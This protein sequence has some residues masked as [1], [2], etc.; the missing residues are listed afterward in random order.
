M[1]KNGV[2]LS[3]LTAG[4]SG[5]SIFAN[6]LF[7]SRADPLIFSLIRNSL[8]ALMLTAVL[9]LFGQ[10]KRLSRVTKKEWGI[11]VA[12][13]AIG[14]GIPFAMF[15]AGLS[16][17]G[18]VNGN[19][20]QK[21]LFLWVALFAV[22]ILKEKIGKVQLLGYLFLFLGMF[23]FGGTYKLV[24][25][26]GAFLVLGATILWA[27]ENVVAKITLKTV[28]PHIVAWG[29]MLF[30]LPFLLAA[31]VVMGK[32]HL[33]MTPTAFAPMPLVVSSVLLVAYVATWYSTLSLAPAT[34]VS[35]IL[36]FAPVVTALLTAIV[37]HE[38]IVK[39]QATNLILL[40]LG[41]ILVVVTRL[42]PKRQNRSV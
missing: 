26:T 22:P 40:S 19:I 10:W 4:I 5:V 28:S 24:P 33:L 27:I 41:T 6:A 15:F 29:R 30:G 9:L 39:T 37:L 3:L 23:V 12:I 18:A 21:T 36:V 1:K 35:S 7:V 14:G 8:V 11:L 13:G 20:L 31:T 25:S 34:V 32:T 2:F 16:Q 42:F 17:I 38:S